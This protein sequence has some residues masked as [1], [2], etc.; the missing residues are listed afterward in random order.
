[1]N[2]HV[3]SLV[4]RPLVNDRSTIERQLKGARDSMEVL[5]LPKPSTFCGKRHHPPHR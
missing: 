1:M 3:A 5:K 4:I 2:K